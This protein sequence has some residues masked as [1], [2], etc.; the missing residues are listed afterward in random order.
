MAFLSPGASLSDP[1]WLRVAWV[2]GL[3]LGSLGVWALFLLCSLR[4]RPPPSLW[5]GQQLGGAKGPSEKRRK[6]TS[7]GKAA[8]GRKELAHLCAP[9]AAKRQSRDFSVSDPRTGGLEGNGGG[10]KGMWRKGAGWLRVQRGSHGHV[11]LLGLLRVFGALM[12][13][14]QLVA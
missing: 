8:P 5:A 7:K 14:K 13:V 1:A 4:G 12:N 6:K 11:W 2:G 10:K 3:V 9:L